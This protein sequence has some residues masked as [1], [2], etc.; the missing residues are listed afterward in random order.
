MQL[1][2]LPCCFRLSDKVETPIKQHRL[3]RGC[4]AEVVFQHFRLEFKTQCCISTFSSLRSIVL[5]A[6]LALGVVG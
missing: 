3:Y 6:L 2:Q 1:A 5:H 4:Y